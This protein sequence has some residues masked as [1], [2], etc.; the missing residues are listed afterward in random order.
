MSRSSHSSFLRNA[1]AYIGPLLF[2]TS[3][4]TAQIIHS[5]LDSTEIIFPSDD[6]GTNYYPFDINNDDVDDLVFIADYDEMWG[7]PSAPEIPV[8]HLLVDGINDSLQFAVEPLTVFYS[9]DVI[10]GSSEYENSTE[11]IINDNYGG[12]SESIFA[13]DDYLGFRKMINGKFHYGWLRL[14]CWTV[15]NSY[16]FPDF[17]IVIKDFGFN[18]IPGEHIKAGQTEYYTAIEETGPGRFRL[19]VSSGQLSI[20]PGTALDY[21]VQ[22][23]DIAGRLVMN[24]KGCNGHHNINISRLKSAIYVIKV[25]SSEDVFIRKIRLP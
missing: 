7:S 6:P 16:W 20:M 18:T 3:F 1:Y 13:E 2:I 11:L 25:F 19:L 15:W 12:G 24:E 22:I 23:F 10:D 21:Q 5:S 14:D 8:R 9:Q 4:S 17:T